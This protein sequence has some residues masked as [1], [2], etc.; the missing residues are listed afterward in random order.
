MDRE[1]ITV[2]DLDQH[3]KRRRGA[4]FEDRF[5][6]TAPPGFFIRQRDCFDPTDQIAQCRVEE[7]VIQG[8]TMGGADQLH[9]ALCDRAGGRGL[10]LAP[11]LVDHDDLRVMIFNRFDHHFV[12]EHRLS[13]LHRRALPTAGCG[14]SPSPRFR[15]RYRQ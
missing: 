12:L 7:Q 4:S 13:H 2:L 11:D 3:I 9:T 14:T 5:L 1:T 6:R 10:K 8:L 15:S